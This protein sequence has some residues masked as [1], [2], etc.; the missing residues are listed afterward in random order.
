MTPPTP[1]Y[2]TRGLLANSSFV[3]FLILP[4]ETQVFYLIVVGCVISRPGKLTIA[5]L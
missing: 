1:P 4:I 3:S 5:F 2:A